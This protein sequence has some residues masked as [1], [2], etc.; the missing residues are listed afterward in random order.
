V[1]CDS[2]CET[3]ADDAIDY[4]IRA[5]AVGVIARDDETMDVLPV[6]P[7]IAVCVVVLLLIL[8]LRWTFSHGH[9]LVARKPHPGSP[10]DYGLLVPC[11]RPGS[12]P[13]GEQ[14]RLRLQAGGVKATLAMTTEGACL[15]V[16]PRDERRARELLRSTK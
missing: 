4:P 5:L 15:F 11:A 13:E 12:M 3:P 14:M 1:E 6:V 8:L 2:L 16:W 9:S 10:G 7:T